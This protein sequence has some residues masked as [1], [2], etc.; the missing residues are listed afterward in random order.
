MLPV[1]HMPTFKQSF[2]SLLCFSSREP[3]PGGGGAGGGKRPG[4]KPS[5]GGKK[6]GTGKAKKKSSTKR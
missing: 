5:K 3:D 1:T 2:S 6:G 4:N